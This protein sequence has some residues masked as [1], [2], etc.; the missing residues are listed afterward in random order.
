LSPDAWPAE[1]TGMARKA[2]LSPDQV[3][4]VIDYLVAASR[5]AQR[6]N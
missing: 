2:G 1:V 5:A 3:S 6:T 4:L